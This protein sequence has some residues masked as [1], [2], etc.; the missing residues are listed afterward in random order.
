[1]TKK[2]E[3]DMSEDT[4]VA[5]T[6][7]E[8]VESYSIYLVGPITSDTIETTAIPL[9]ELIRDKT[10]VDFYLS[11]IGGEIPPAM[12]IADII[13]RCSAPLNIYLL[14]EVVSAGF[15]IALAGYNNDNVKTYAYPSTALMWH[16]GM[17]EGMTTSPV[18]SLCEYSQFTADQWEREK[19]FI[20]AHS[21]LTV[22]QIHE[23]CWRTDRW[24]YPNELLELGIIDEIL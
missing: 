17:I 2:N 16:S 24:F 21:K 7:E 3:V 9:L 5:S 20:A 22:E 18:H 13:D 6:Q 1:M 10:P 15:L 8:F 12:L 14:G 11:T 23:E 19:E 4:G